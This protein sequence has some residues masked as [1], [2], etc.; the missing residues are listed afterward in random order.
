MW[1]GLQRAHDAGT[2]SISS[3]QVLGSTRRTA[4]S[5]FC[6]SSTPAPGSILQVH[7]CL[8]CDLLYLIPTLA[9][10]VVSM[11]SGQGSSPLR[12]HVQ[13][14]QQAASQQA[15][16]AETVQLRFCVA[17]L[18]PQLLPVRLRPGA[19]TGLRLLPGHPFSDHSDQVARPLPFSPLMAPVM[20]AWLFMQT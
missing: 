3:I 1:N 18:Q 7:A 8:C 10:F 14:Q 4:T 16:A 2:T 11:C 9:S 6:G 17:G 19:P 5:V 12:M 15:I 13:A 20:P